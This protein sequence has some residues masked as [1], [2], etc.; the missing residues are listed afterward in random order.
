MRLTT[1]VAALREIQYYQN[2]VVDGS[3]IPP[4]AFQKLVKQICDQYDVQ[5]K[6]GLVSKFRW[7]K[8]AIFALQAV[9]EDVLTMIFEMTYSAPANATD[10]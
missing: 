4:R 10:Q 7:E 6:D 2:K 1:L 3:F 5:D 8:D 9:T